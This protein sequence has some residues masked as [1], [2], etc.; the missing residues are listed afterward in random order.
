MNSTELN[1]N[2]SEL[3]SP[4]KLHNQ[5]NDFIYKLT[6]LTNTAILIAAMMFIIL[7]VVLNIFALGFNQEVS[8]QPQYKIGK[9]IIVQK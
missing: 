4:A 8:A 3:F 5:P 7:A 9:T 6:A 2:T 1:L